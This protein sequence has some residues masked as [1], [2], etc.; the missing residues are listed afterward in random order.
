MSRADF[1]V[2]VIEK[3]TGG[4]ESAK[5]HVGEGVEYGGDKVKTAGQKMQKTE[6]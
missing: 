5:E 3:L 2:Q 1:G 4:A 6:L